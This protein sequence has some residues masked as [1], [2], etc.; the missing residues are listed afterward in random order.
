[1]FVF[2]CDMY[3]C[4]RPPPNPSPDLFLTK[5]VLTEKMKQ[6][7]V[8]IKNSAK[9]VQS[10]PPAPHIILLHTFATAETLKYNDRKSNDSLFDLLMFFGQNERNTTMKKTDNKLDLYEAVETLRLFI[11]AT[12]RLL[13]L[14]LLIHFCYLQSGLLQEKRKLI[15]AWGISSDTN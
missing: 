10:S 8:R 14:F 3:S 4:H 6:R 1:M 15:Y 9:F 2:C 11:S 5:M 12:S 7:I 13:S